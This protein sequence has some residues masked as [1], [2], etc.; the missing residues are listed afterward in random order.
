MG[1][2][3]ETVE[4]PL[5]GEADQD[6]LHTEVLAPR[7]VEEALAHRRR[8]VHGPLAAHASDSR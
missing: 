5:R 3:G 4:Q 1:R 7:Q 8:D 2:L 6:V